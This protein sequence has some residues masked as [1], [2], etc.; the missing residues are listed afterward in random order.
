MVVYDLNPDTWETEAGG[1][2]V[3]GYGLSSETLPQNKQTN[4]PNN[5]VCVCVCV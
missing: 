2:C 3:E 5:S 1:S 4:K